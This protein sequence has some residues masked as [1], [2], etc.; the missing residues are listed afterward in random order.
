MCNRL[1]NP[2]TFQLNMANL[3]DDEGNPHHRLASTMKYASSSRTQ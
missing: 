1:F 3:A 2:Q